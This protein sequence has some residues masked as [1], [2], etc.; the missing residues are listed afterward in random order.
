MSLVAKLMICM[1]SHN[2]I[3]LPTEQIDGLTF[4]LVKSIVLI[5]R[6][7]YAGIYGLDKGYETCHLE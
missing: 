6:R 5:G 4:A 2:L 1:W 7:E 3:G